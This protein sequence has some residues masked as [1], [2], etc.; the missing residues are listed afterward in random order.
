VDGA[1]PATRRRRRV[2][3]TLIVL[4]VVLLLVAYPAAL[5]LTAY[6]H[7]GR[8]NALPSGIADTPGRTY[9]VVGSDSRAGLS[10]AQRT[11]LHTGTAAGQRSDTILLLHVPANGGPTVL[12]SIPRDSYVAIPGHSK[13]KINAA[14]SFGGPQL[15]ARTVEGAT[16]VQIDDYV[17]IGFGGFASVV[18]AVGG[19]TVCPTRSYDDP[20]A[21]LKIGK[22][23]QPVDGTT[24]LAYARARYSDPRG[25]LGRVDRQREVL[26]AIV[27]KA[28]SPVTLANPFRTFPLASSGAATLTVDDR[29]GPMAVTQF[30]LGVRDASS[31]GGLSLTVPVA[32]TADRSGAG[33]VVLWDAAKAKIVF[34][35]LRT[36]DTTPII[37][38]AAAEKAALRP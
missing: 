22:G 5:G 21:K 29:T 28:L 36:S 2:P 12:I 8:V 16:G 13:N 14:F 25:D 11:T 33:N 31:G 35:A 6:T 9:L 23:C 38:I 20:K 10:A 19:V 7:L 4:L 27:K 3:V 15:L 18:D 26:A 24:A 1:G 30:A 32:G 37:A 17:E 34:D